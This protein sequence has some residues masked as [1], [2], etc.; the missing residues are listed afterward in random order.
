MAAAAPGHI[1][2][3][4]TPAFLHDRHSL[5]DEWKTHMSR[6]LGRP[7]ELVKRD[8]YRETMDLVQSGQ[9]DF[10]W[11][12]DYP[13]LRLRDIV[14]LLAVPLYQ[15]KPYYHC[16]L[17]VGAG[18][19]DAKGFEDL[20]GKIF[21]YADRYSN[22]G[23]LTPRYELHKIGADP[24]RFFRKTFFTLSH[25][26]V[27]E[28]VASG[29]ASGGAVDSY[30]WESLAVIE[31]ELTRKTRIIW[32]SPPFGFPPLVAHRSNASDRDFQQMQQLLLGMAT[33][34]DGQ[35]LLQE[36]NL[37]GFSVQGPEIYDGVAEM[38][39]AFGEFDPT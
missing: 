9:L 31:P 7:V 22:T 19:T 35:K 21:A 24:E 39:R 5:L 32:R 4:V 15:G 23:Y 36:L 34:P 1:R 37:D 18:N 26:K 27:V 29:L 3:G 16:Y 6:R 33:D 2:F 12:C 30:V 25:R 11:I 10:A 17:I 38:M 8:S 13:Y 14:R 28:A 20:R